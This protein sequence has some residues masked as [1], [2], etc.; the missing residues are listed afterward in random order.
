MN[1]PTTAAHKTAAYGL[2]LDELATLVGVQRSKQASAENVSTLPGSEHDQPLPDGAKG[3][4]PVAPDPV[5]KAT[6]SSSA[7]GDD[8]PL[9]GKNTTVSGE[10]SPEQPGTELPMVTDDPKAGAGQGGG[11]A[12]QAN[13]LLALVVTVREKLAQEAAPGSE[14]APSIAEATPPAGTDEDE[15]TAGVIE[16]SREM[17]SKIAAVAMTSEK[18]RRAMYA[19]LLDQSGEK[20]ANDAFEVLYALNDRLAEKQAADDTEN[21]LLMVEKR[22]GELG[23]TPEAYYAQVTAGRTPAAPAPAGRSKTAADHWADYGRKIAQAVMDADASG[24]LP[25]EPEPELTEEDSLAAAIQELLAS[26]EI[27]PEELMEVQ[28]VIEQ[29]QQGGG[30]G[31]GL[32]PAEG[33]LPPEGG[34]GVEGADPLA[35]VLPPGVAEDPAISDPAAAD[36]GEGTV[37]EEEKQASDSPIALFCAALRR[38]NRK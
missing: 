16:L 24:V 27:T 38:T 29:A 23:I 34:E 19:A 5:A 8:L 20:A 25:A 37:V 32:M 6:T 31:S 1:T 14:G 4:F 12:K 21:I 28:Q 17:L 2:V 18:G 22:A 10:A 11:G 3:E 36:A 33:G 7:P 35:G 26:G 9:V 30:D 15:K 13:E